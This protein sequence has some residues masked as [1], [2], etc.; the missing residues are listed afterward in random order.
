MVGVYWNLVIGCKTLKK[1]EELLVGNNVTPI[2][3]LYFVFD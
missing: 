3:I 1:L 2:V